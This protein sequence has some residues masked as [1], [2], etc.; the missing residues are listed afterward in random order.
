[1]RWRDLLPELLTLFLTVP[2]V[3]LQSNLPLVS[4][5]QASAR[6]RFGNLPISFEANRGQAGTEVKFL[7]R[8]LGY[9][10]LLT[11]QGITLG[12]RPA[13]TPLSALG[14]S[15]AETQ[16]KPPFTTVQLRLIGANPNSEII[17]EDPLS[18]KVNYF[19]GADPTKWRT[20]VPTYSK[21]RY[22]NV[23]SGVDLLYYGNHRQLEYD[24]VLAP[25]SNPA[26]IQLEI[27]GATR[28]RLDSE[29][30]LVLQ[31]EG[32]ELY[33]HAPVVYQES[34]QGHTSVSSSY[35]LLDATHVGF[36]IGRY[37][38]TR[39]LVI[40][41]SIIYS[42]YLGGSGEDQPSGI[43]VDS[44]GDLYIAGYTDSTDFPLASIG[45]LPA[46]DHVFLAKLDPTGSNLIYADYIGGDSEDYGYAL[47]LD[48]ANE[49]FVTGSTSSNDFPL[50]NPFQAQYPGSYNGFLTKVSSD[51]SSL[52]YSTYFGG[53][54]S[55]QPS[56][57]AIDGSGN[58]I[59]AGSTSSTNLPLA[60]AYQGTVLENQ[61]DL[62]GTYGFVSK[63]SSDGSSLVYSTYFG[64]NT[65]IALNCGGTLCWPTPFSEIN[66]LAL[67]EAGNAYVAGVTNTYNFPATEGAYLATNSVPANGIV[68]FVSKF[69]GA[70]DL[71][72]STY[73]YEASGILSNVNAIAV[74]TA[75]EAVITG[76][77]YS[78]GTFPVTTTTICNP[79]VSGA[80]CGYA[81]VTKF[82]STASSLLYSTFLGANNGATPQAITLD[83]AGDAYILASTL[84]SSFSAINGLEEYSGGSDLLVVEIDPLAS[85]QLFA[86]YLGGS[87]DEYPSGISLGSDASIYI[88][89][90]TDSTNIPVTQG[91]AQPTFGGGTDAFV[92]R[93][94][95]STEPGVLLNPSQLQFPLQS[96]GTVSQPQTIQLRN[97]GGATL[98]I[99]SL[100]VSGDFAETN[101]CSNLAQNSQCTILVTFSPTADGL[102]SGTITILDNAVGSSQTVALTGTGS[103]GIAAVAPSSLEF[104]PVVI[105]ATSSPQS[106]TLANTGNGSIAL[107]S[108]QIS[109]P[110]L[111]TNNCPAQLQANTSC[112]YSVVFSP[113]VS[114][115]LSGSLA[116]TTGAQTNAMDIALSGSGADFNLVL[117]NPSQSASPGRTATYQLSVS[118]E[119]AVFPGT[120]ALACTGMPAQ[121]TCSFSPSHLSPGAT[122]A[123][124][125]L[126]VTTAG[127]NSSAANKRPDERFS[128]VWLPVSLLALFGTVWMGRMPGAPKLRLLGLIAFLGAISMC[129]C[130]GGT[131]IAKTV[132]SGTAAGS[133]SFTLTG[134]AGPLQHSVKATLVVQ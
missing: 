22:R 3:A 10:A 27:V 19:I 49:V 5:G 125:I 128:A 112:T 67:D 102:R 96:I 47:A 122:S 131:G 99:S 70:G 13:R 40:D 58:A 118:S 68:G 88:A 81:F 90:S 117:A 54:G 119:G 132:E 52:L 29:G 61:G 101:D 51:G 109:G 72:Y 9:K 25:G 26:D 71:N 48:S 127:T 57:L 8:G 60:N 66:G 95:P 115:S 114:G 12:L 53:N 37:D 78:D 100:T 84:S 18:G 43:A 92:F 31:V 21:V 50:V 75:G 65:N 107:G 83:S 14:P 41:P 35:V 110:F 108:A 42:T 111:Q 77:A 129:G 86:S 94:G 36:R 64:G 91:V 24:F 126:T 89:G 17:G 46:G 76:A 73:F 2:A 30:S 59:I 133:Y 6:A 93:I 123:S 4:Q 7:S 33:F 1:M 28:T 56:T 23:Y 79:V 69:D 116:I 39:E 106:I 20:N 98:S 130:A 105:G 38:R 63:F 55:D 74:D 113:T 16:S 97:P 45:S 15:A 44:S 134:S 80:A 120:I 32:C 82:N 104:S 121:I 124:S 11:A 34:K 85:T 87:D 103:G 62:L